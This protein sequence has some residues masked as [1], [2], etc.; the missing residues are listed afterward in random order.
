MSCPSKLE[1]FI[2]FPA[3]QID[4]LQLPLQ[5]S[6]SSSS[7]THGTN[8]RPFCGIQWS[9][10]NLSVPSVPYD[11][12]HRMVWDKS[13]ITPSHGISS[14]LWKVHCIKVWYKRWSCNCTC[15]WSVQEHLLPENWKSCTQSF[16]FWKCSF[17]L[18]N[19]MSKALRLYHQ[20]P[21]TPFATFLYLVLLTKR[22]SV[23]PRVANCHCSL[24]L[25]LW[26]CP[27]HSLSLS[28][29]LTFAENGRSP[30][31]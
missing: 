23:V 15:S 18:F 21:P 17:T 13:R 25:K 26:Q 31:E 12:L 29:P 10:A 5:L 16:T 14:C 24:T 28:L 30:L 19:Y 3:W 7:Y 20:P 6:S 9:P 27:D 22:I 8:T 2:G 4:P 11:L 1:L